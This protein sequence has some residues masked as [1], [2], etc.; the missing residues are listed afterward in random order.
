[1]ATEEASKQGCDYYD[2]AVIGAG[3]MGA[4]IAG[5][6]A[7]NGARVAVHDRSDFDRK[8]GFEIMRADMKQ[9]EEEG[10]ISKEGR[11]Q[12]LDHVFLVNSLEEVNSQRKLARY[13]H[14]CCA[15]RREQQ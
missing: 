5:A 11:E 10:L 14:R 4:S 15:S 9:H 1:M 6:L 2:F 13:G 3:R 12:A 8:K 7:L